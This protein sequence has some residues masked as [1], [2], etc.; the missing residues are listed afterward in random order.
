MLTTG[1]AMCVR[2]CVCVCVCVWYSAVVHTQ[3]QHDGPKTRS[4]VSFCSLPLQAL[5][6]FACRVRGGLQ[7]GGEAET[8]EEAVCVCV[9]MRVY[10]CV[11]TCV[12]VA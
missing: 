2:V 7:R 8:A 12:C 11:C 3:R 10:A 6:S 4:V 1:V 5:A 9:C